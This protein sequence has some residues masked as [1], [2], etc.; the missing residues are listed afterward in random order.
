[1]ITQ[2]TPIAK[3]AL[4][5]TVLVCSGCTRS[6]SNPNYHAELTLGVKIAKSTEEIVAFQKNLEQWLRE[7][8]FIPTQM[9]EWAG[10]EHHRAEEI[11]AWYRGSYRNSEPFFLQ[12]MMTPLGDSGLGRT[13]IQV[14][15]W[16]PITFSKGYP[17]D[18]DAYDEEMKSHFKEFRAEFGEWFR[19]DWQP[20]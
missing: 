2:K 18:D 11:D 15:Q 5:L 1:M 6:Q 9:P 3:L 14:N 7:H 16:F 8:A 20:K 17:Q 19:P 10:P 4:L 13:E 12:V